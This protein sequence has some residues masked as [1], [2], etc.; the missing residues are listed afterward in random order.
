MLILI[1]WHTVW[2]VEILRQ[3]QYADGVLLYGNIN[4]AEHQ[5]RRKEGGRCC[6]LRIGMCEC[7]APTT[8]MRKPISYL[9]R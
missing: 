7:K 4:A 1:F 6:V 5:H 8:E 9:V 3:A 2:S